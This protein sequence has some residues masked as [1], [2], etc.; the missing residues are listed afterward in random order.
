MAIGSLKEAAMATDD[1][2]VS[3]EALKLA[4]DELSGVHLTADMAAVKYAGALD[5]VAFSIKGS[6]G[7]WDINT[8]AGRANRENMIKAALASHDLMVA[9][10]DEGATTREL[11]GLYT[12]HRDQLLEVARKLDISEKEAKKLID[13]YLAIPKSIDTKIN[14]NTSEAQRAFDEF[15]TLN[16]GRQ[17]PVYLIEKQGLPAKDGGYFGYASGGPVRGPGGS[18]TDSIPARISR[19]E[20][21]VNA[22]ATRRNLPL[23]EAINSGRGVGG[24]GGNTTIYQINSTV[25]PTANL[26]AVGQ[27]IVESIQAFESRSGKTWRSN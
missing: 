2:R 19:G 26:S 23:L 25:A 11:N 6:S 5:K 14:A 18:R 10:A 27:E 15:V 24:M 8:A 1:M 7:E 16:S 21:V 9:R 3:S 17:I 12:V 4:L 20:F 13:R 22:A